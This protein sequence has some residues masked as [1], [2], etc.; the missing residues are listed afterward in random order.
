MSKIFKTELVWSLPAVGESDIIYIRRSDEQAFYWDAAVEDYRPI[1]YQDTTWILEDEQHGDYTGFSSFDLS[2][3]ASENPHEVLVTF[4]IAAG[5]SRNI[6]LSAHFIV[7]T[8]SWEGTAMPS[9][10][11]D[12]N[13]NGILAVEFVWTS[14]LKRVR[15]ITG[16]TQFKQGT[17]FS[18]NDAEMKV[19]YR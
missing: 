8:G 16:W 2:S 12:A 6:T 10:F 14:Q 17:S 11:Y 5:G 4:E 19:Y 7:P 18:S 15:I 13:Y 1:S 9:W 3:I